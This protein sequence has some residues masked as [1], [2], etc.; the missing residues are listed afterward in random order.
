MYGQIIADKKENAYSRFFHFRA[1]TPKINDVI[2][3]VF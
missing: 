1:E 2:E 3:P